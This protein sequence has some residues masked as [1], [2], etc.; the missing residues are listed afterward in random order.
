MD[1]SKMNCKKSQGMNRTSQW[2][3]AVCTL[4]KQAGCE[5]AIN[6]VLAQVIETQRETINIAVVGGP[7][8][9][10]SSRIN[11]LLGRKILPV[12]GLASNCAFSI[13]PT[14][15]GEGEG[16][17]VGDTSRPLN[18][19]ASAI[20]AAPANSK[21]YR[22]HVDSDWLSA[23]SIQLLE[24]P[25]LDAT[26]E[27]LDVLIEEC[28]RG[29]DLVILLIDALMPVR[30]S[31]HKF[32]N[33]CV[34]RNLPLVVAVSKADKI[35]NGE[36]ETVMAYV[37]KH[38]D[39]HNVG[40]PVVDTCITPT[41][42]SGIDELRQGI[43]QC[44]SKTDLSAIRR[45]EV[46][47]ALQIA[48]NIITVALQ[49][50]AEAQRKSQEELDRE[51][52]QR[53][54]QI[55]GMNLEWVKLDQAMHQRRQKVDSQIRSFLEENQNTLLEGLFYDLERNNDIKIWW[56]RDL[57]FRLHRELNSLAG[58]LSAS[59]N[60]NITGDVKWLQGELLRR[61]KFPLQ[62][63][64]EPTVLVG[65][66]ELTQGEQK[67]LPLSDGHLFRI[68]SRLGTAASVIMAG[69]LLA[70]AG[71]GGISLAASVLAGLTAEQVALY[72]TRRDRNIVHS[73]IQKIVQQASH[74]YATDVSR[75]LKAGYDEILTNLKQHQERWQQAQLQSL[76]A[77]TQ[78]NRANRNFDWQ[79]LQSE[80]DALKNEIAT[81][82]TF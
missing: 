10:K 81:E 78:K 36:R 79:V 15:S 60:K 18:D 17:T 12:S 37:V 4:A 63:F 74:E 51:I 31:E 40:I 64:A 66:A 46:R 11:A 29:V 19:L 44:L 50:S 33:I 28:L 24:R 48:I 26:D 71:I 72:N 57:P 69:S 38:V 7:N 45:K 42:T 25:A 76:T 68:I 30:R 55:E 27:E 59:I 54:Q 34:E 65:E 80:I 3:T 20:V 47:H 9:G 39:S 82:T 49:A 13:Q 53:Q 58:Q 70:T 2:I 52:K 67:T 14:R 62:F 8:S 16:F 61:L 56:Q 5:Q 41:L 23:K 6:P 32:M 21:E 43:E 22:V 1:I 77:Y 75:K 73:E 35:P